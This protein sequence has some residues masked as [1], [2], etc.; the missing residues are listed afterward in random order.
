MAETAIAFPVLLMAALGLLQFSVFYHSQN[1]MTESVQEGARVAA[2]EDRTVSDGVAYAQVLL[3]AGIGPS[4]D[5]VQVQGIDGGNAVAIE[6]QARLKLII[7]WAVNATL[8]LQS[9]AVVS[10]EK[11]RVGPGSTN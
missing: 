4:A 8:P 2:E 10:K 11:F 9:R 3:K 5:Q 1:V 6:A 7:P